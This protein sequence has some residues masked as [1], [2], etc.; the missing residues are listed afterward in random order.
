MTATALLCRVCD[1]RDLLPVIDLGNQPWCNHFLKP[2]EVGKEPFYPLRVLF[3]RACHT[4]QLDFTVKKEIMFGDH[5]YLS[6]VTSSLSEHFR[7]VAEEVDRAFFQG[8]AGKSVLDI[9]SND[10]TQ[11]KHFQALGY[12]V[13][14]VESSRTTARIAQE[15]GVPTMNNFFNEE[16][17]QKIGRKFDVFNASGVF[18]HLEELH[19]VCRAIRSGLKPDGV[20]VVQFLYMKSIME[21]L[22]FDQIYHEHLLYYTL[23][24]VGT[25]LRRHGL[26]MFDATLK[27]IHGGSVVGYVGHAG[28]RPVTSGL[29]KMQEAE[30]ESGCNTLEAYREFERRIRRMKE[31]NLAYLHA[32][33]EAGKRV[34]GFGAPVKGNT[35]LNYFGVGPELIECLVEKNAL[36]RGLISPGMHIP[37]RMEEEI[38]DPPDI[39]YVLAWNFKEEILRNNRTLRE[40]G[41]EFYFPVDPDRGRK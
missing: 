33:K 24:T 31:E 40:R 26:E 13:L 29:R 6:G 35:L 9:G 11:L 15:A 14:G 8:R 37:V 28:K 1:S 25:L 27:P 20:F 41:V 5:T 19:S 30:R 10:G 18:F 39:Y 38:G 3:C 22:A 12:E 16:V 21:N 32:A 7:Q 34:F 4:S 2:E 23:E 17:M 36:R